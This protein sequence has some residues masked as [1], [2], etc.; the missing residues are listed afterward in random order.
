MGRAERVE[1]RLYVTHLGFAPHGVTRRARQEMFDELMPVRAELR[2]H[3]SDHPLAFTD[4]IRRLDALERERGESLHEDAAQ[5]LHSGGR[6]CLTAGEG[7]RHAVARED[8]DSALGTRSADHERRV[9]PRARHG[10]ENRDVREG[11]PAT[12]SAPSETFLLF[13][14]RRVHVGVGRGGRHRGQRLC[15]HGGRRPSADKTENEVG[16]GDGFGDVR[17][18]G[19]RLGRRRADEID[20]DDVGASVHEV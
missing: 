2:R 17:R 14:R 12:C 4:G 10:G 5:Q 8:L 1:V 16:A 18:T 15:E 7:R 19:M 13:R 11:D 9:C 20:G 6:P 3:L